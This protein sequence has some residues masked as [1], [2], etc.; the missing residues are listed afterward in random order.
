[1][2]LI[3]FED[4]HLLVINKPAGMNTHSPSPY[5]GEGIYEWLKNRDARW[6]ELAIIH[7]LDKE[8][9]GILV[10]GKTS[11]ANRSLSQQFEGR[12]VRKKYLLL[13]DRA[14]RFQTLTAKSALVRSGEKYLSRPVHAGADVAETEFRPAVQ[15]SG[16]ILG[17][18]AII[19]EP[20]TGRTHQIRVHA[21]EHGFP[22]LGD[23]LYGGTSASRLFLHAHELTL[24]HPVSNETMTFVA[25]LDFDRE[26]RSELRHRLI[27]VSETNAFR[28]INS[29]SDFL[30]GL[31]VDRFGDYLLAQS[32]KSLEQ[33][34]VGLLREMM[35]QERAKGVYFKN[36]SRHI[37][38][39]APKDT[40]PQ[41]V[42]GETAPEEFV[43]RENSVN[44]GIRFI[45]GY[46]VGIF[47]DQR[48]NR[49]RLRTGYIA[50]Q[51]SFSANG[52]EILNTFSYTCAFSV[53]AAKGGARVTSLDLS[54]KYLEWGKRNFELNGILPAEHD[55]IYGDTFDWLRRFGKKN[56]Q[57]DAVLLDPPT[58]SQSKEYGVFRADK[59]YGELVSAAIGVLKS[60][61]ILLCSTNAAELKPETFLEIIRVA[62]AAKGRKIVKQHYAPQPPD[63]PISREEPAYLKTVWLQIS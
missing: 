15:S 14:P 32:E 28:L 1:M 58:F 54:K 53:S 36:L 20:I 7:R 55:F 34:N 10:F 16:L 8:T 48:D 38:G 50:S 33:G 61:G 40:S 43:I 30:A 19:A 41:K 52:A 37:R 56:R 26:P 42:I 62:V 23:N 47:L 11:L 51:F 60:G 25:P 39:S 29:A 21:A 3:I 6:A 17:T 24:G 57:F 9:S 45:E 4:E 59:D 2:S 31:Y 12:T 13:T 27:D 35:N 63:F 18:F 5:A 44:Y 46:S 22:I 49:R